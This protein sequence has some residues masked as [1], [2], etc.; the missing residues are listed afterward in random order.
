MLIN[1]MNLR[2]KSRGMIFNPKR[3]RSNQLCACGCGEYT[4]I[5]NRHDNKDKPNKYLRGHN[6]K[7][8]NHHIWNGGIYKKN[9]YAYVLKK[10]HPK[11]IKGGYVR[12]SHLVAET[13]LGKPLPS[14]AIVHHVSGIRNDDR[15]QNLVICENQKF[16]LLL[17]RREIAL[18]KCGHANWRKC[19]FCKQYDDPN[20]LC[21][22]SNGFVCHKECRNQ[23]NRDRY[24]G[25]PHHY[26]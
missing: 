24:K 20:N 1:L 4:F 6:Q 9:G 25:S 10:G 19:P 7:G 16:H 5:S 3:L 11:A 26:W 18:R 8:K 17:H 12:R 2:A 23:Y 15:P 21:I 14:K 22:Y 13:I